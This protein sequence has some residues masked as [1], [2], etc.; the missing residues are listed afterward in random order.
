MALAFLHENGIV[1]TDMKPTNAVFPYEFVTH[2]LE[3]KLLIAHFEVLLIDLAP[4]VK[5][6]DY[7][8]INGGN[9]GVE[10]GTREY[11]APEVVVGKTYITFY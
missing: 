1:H 2:Y 11:R 9:A 7:I 4:M 3:G 8:S 6:S 5:L 10:I